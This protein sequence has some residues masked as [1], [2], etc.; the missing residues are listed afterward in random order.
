MSHRYAPSQPAT[1]NIW[2]GDEI[3]AE[4]APLAK[5]NNTDGNPETFRRL[6]DRITALVGGAFELKDCGHSEAHHGWQ[7]FRSEKSW[8]A[9]VKYRFPEGQDDPEIWIGMPD[10][11][12]ELFIEKRRLSVQIAGEKGWNFFGQTYQARGLTAY[13][14]ISLN[15]TT[16]TTIC[17]ET[18]IEA[19]NALHIW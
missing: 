8:I 5:I 17:A 11:G 3:V 14:F 13:E 10:I 12:G 2:M 1:Y 15:H 19:A 16:L 18:A 4:D 6:L 9:N 7:V